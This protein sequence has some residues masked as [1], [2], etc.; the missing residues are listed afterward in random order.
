MTLSRKDNKYIQSL[1]DK[2]VQP[3]N[4]K[5]HEIL[6]TGYL[7]AIHSQCIKHLPDSPHHMTV[8]ARTLDD[9]LK[10][11]IDPTLGRVLLDNKCMDMMDVV[12]TALHYYMSID[13]EKESLR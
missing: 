5:E 4:K 9:V 1:R 12:D 11:D 6:A 8:L 10:L 13:K 3:L 2:G 7:M